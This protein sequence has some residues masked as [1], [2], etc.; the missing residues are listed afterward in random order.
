[1]DQEREKLQCSSFPH[2][3]LVM[4]NTVTLKQKETEARRD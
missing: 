2:N 3:N 4:G 1:M